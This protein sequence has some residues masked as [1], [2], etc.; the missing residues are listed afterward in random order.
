[1]PVFFTICTKRRRPFLAQRRVADVIV[2][3]L[4]QN[5]QIHGCAVIAYCIMPDHL[6]LVACVS[7]RGGDVLSM[8]E[9]FKKTTGGALQHVAGGTVWQRSF[10]DRH[11]RRDDDVKA[12]I[13]YILKNPRRAGLCS[14]DQE[15][16]Y[17]A[18][19]GFPTPEN[20]GPDGGP[21]P[22]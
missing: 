10:D 8:V 4:Q 12:M 5:A 15:W 16:P 21:A 6:H 17:A 11:A 20:G 19:S 13:D 7:R 2:S 3:A 9:G 14:P 18:F 1:M 22:P